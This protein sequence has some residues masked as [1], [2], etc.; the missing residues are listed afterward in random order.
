MVFATKL[1]NLLIEAARKRPAVAEYLK[2]LDKRLL[3]IGI[4]GWEEY[5]N[6]RLSETNKKEGCKLG[7]KKEGDS[8][9][10][11]IEDNFLYSHV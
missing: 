8:D 1:S 5:E 2:G 6:T 11:E 3:R 7:E 9:K 10:I 4:A